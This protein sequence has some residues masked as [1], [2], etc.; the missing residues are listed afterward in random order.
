MML[1]LSTEEESEAVSETAV[2]PDGDQNVALIKRFRLSK[3]AL[4]IIVALV[5]LTCV[6]AYFWRV[7]RQESMTAGIQPKSIAVLPFKLLDAD[8]DDEYL[9]LGLTDALITR[10]GNL[11]QVEVRLTSLVRKYSRQDTDPVEAGQAAFSK[12]ANAF[13]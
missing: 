4:A 12:P 1:C 9:G 10:L 3:R 5:A 6:A 8:A 11:R 7:W 2:V 13:A